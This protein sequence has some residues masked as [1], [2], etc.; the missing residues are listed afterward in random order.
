[1]AKSRRPRKTKPTQRKGRPQSSQSSKRG[2]VRVPRGQSRRAKQI[3]RER[4]GITS[5]PNYYLW[6]TG[7]QER[8]AARTG[9]LPSVHS[10]T[11]NPKFQKAVNDVLGAS[12]L[13]KQ[14]PNSKLA[15][16]LVELGVRN[17]S[18]RG[19]VGNSPDK[20]QPRPRSHRRGSSARSN[21]RRGAPH[22]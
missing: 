13:R 1:M 21:L 3:R 18:F 2:G 4:R 12:K 8:E 17:P 19:I 22:P 5:N 11:R 6:I 7:F 15:K 10:V 20:G 9:K 14:G 16:A